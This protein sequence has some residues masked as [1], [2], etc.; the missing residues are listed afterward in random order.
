MQEYGASLF[1]LV[2]NT[3][4]QEREYGRN[5]VRIQALLRSSYYTTPMMYGVQFQFTGPCFC[6]NQRYKSQL[7]T[8]LSH[9]SQR[10]FNSKQNR[11]W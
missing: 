11:E 2:M 3:L 7:I 9:N 5:Y 1:C 8:A 6:G 4:W 10:V